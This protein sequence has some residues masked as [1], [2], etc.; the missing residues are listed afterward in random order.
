M[1]IINFTDAVSLVSTIISLQYCKTYYY[2]YY[3]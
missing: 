1:D 2:Y 3:Y